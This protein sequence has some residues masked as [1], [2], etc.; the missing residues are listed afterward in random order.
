MVYYSLLLSLIVWPILHIRNG[1]AGNTYH[2]GSKPLGT[3]KRNLPIL[4]QPI[5]TSEEENIGKHVTSSR[6]MLIPPLCFRPFWHSVRTTVLRVVWPQ[7]LQF[8][9]P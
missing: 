7:K 2:W 9:W 4:I 5:L 1:N 3:G 6:P 8:Q